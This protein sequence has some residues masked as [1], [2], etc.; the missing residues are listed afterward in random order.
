MSDITS[1]RAFRLLL[2]LAVAG[3][4]VA[5]MSG[6]RPHNVFAV[7]PPQIDPAALGVAS[8]VQGP[9]EPTEQRWLC[10]EPL[11]TGSPPRDL[12][13]AQRMLEQSQAWQFST[14]AGQKVAVIDTGVN[15]HPRLPALQPGGDFVSDTDGTVDCDG[16]GTLVA[17][18]IGARPSPDD[19]F[20]GVAPDA[21]IVAIRQS[22]EAFEARGNSP[23]DPSGEIVAGGYGNVLTLAAAIVR[24][25]DLGATV[26]NISEVACGPIGSAPPDAALGAAVKHAYDRNVVVVVAAGNLEQGRT[27]SQ[28]NEGNG[29]GAVQTVVSPAWF[30]PYVLAVASVEADGTASPFSIRGP[31]VDVA[32]PG[33][34]IVSLDSRPGSTGLVNSIP[35]ADGPGNID[36]TSFSVAFVSG[37][38]TLVRA[39][40]PELNAQQVMDRIVRTAQAPGAGR[41]DAIG[42]GLIDPVAA[43]TAYLP[44]RPETAAVTARAIRPPAP[45]PSIDPTPRYVAG[46]G[47]AILLAGLAAGLGLALLWRRPGNEPIDP[48]DT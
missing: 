41:D 43:L 3:L 27:C 22:S 8:A 12:P 44:D 1:A 16:H 11:L 7:S 25:V 24:A 15:R 38:A 5:V 29:W 33:R 28:Q 20:A 35:S 45:P 36:G 9:L 46:I 2:R 42:H 26:I 21:E 40:Y 37:L 47:S 31:W 48:T 13:A 6:G 17:G 34:A 10:A 14:G 23:A 30:T 39:R 4:L 32:A 19:G 18:L